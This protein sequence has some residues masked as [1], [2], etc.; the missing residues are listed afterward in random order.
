VPSAIGGAVGTRNYHN[1][2]IRI[3]H[4][5]L[6][7]IRPTILRERGIAMLWH[8]HIH[9]HINCALNHGVKIFHLKPEQHTVFVRSVIGVADLS[10]VV[11]NLETVEF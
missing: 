2:P 6:P 4:P 10:M 9:F 5:T 7:M 3:F 11:L 8:N 1:M